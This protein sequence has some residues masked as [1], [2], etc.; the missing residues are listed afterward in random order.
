[1]DARSHRV[2]VDNEVDPHVDCAK[3]KV[4]LRRAVS[5]RMIVEAREPLPERKGF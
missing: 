5:V 4:V 1:M 2:P 3:V